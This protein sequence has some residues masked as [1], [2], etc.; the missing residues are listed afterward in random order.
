MKKLF[1]ALLWL[2]LAGWCYGSG[3][4]DP[5]NN[6]TLVVTGYAI[7][8]KSPTVP[9]YVT[10]YSDGAKGTGQ[11]LGL[12]RANLARPDATLLHG[13]TFQLPA[14][15]KDGKPHTI[16]VYRGDAEL[17]QPQQTFTFGTT[18]TPAVTLSRTDI[19]FPDQKIGAMSTPMMVDVRNT[20]TG[21]L[22]I[23]SIATTGT[24]FPVSASTCKQT[25]DPDTSCFVS[26]AF[27]PQAIGAKSDTLLINTNAQGSPHKVTLHG[28]AVSPNNN[29]NQQIV[30]QT[31]DVSTN[32]L[33]VWLNFNP[34]QWSSIKVYFNDDFKTIFSQGPDFATSFVW[35]DGCGCGV[36]VSGS[37]QL[38]NLGIK[39]KINPALYTGGFE[40]RLGDQI[41]FTTAK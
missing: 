8:D 20:G 25:L 30:I 35:P 11:R 15:L 1:T 16:F 10:I 34:E 24:D 28:V 27:S 5:I 22:S 3:I 39:I 29:G 14:N 6:Q 9:D 19:G 41:I 18:G 33:S 26:I 31:L 23:T 13:F 4:V 32:A 37:A 7:D 2:A 38:K 12:V 36:A 17:L 21:Q 40:I